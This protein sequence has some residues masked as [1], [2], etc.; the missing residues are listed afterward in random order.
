MYSEARANGKMNHK[1]V[2]I[3]HPQVF[4]QRSYQGD[5]N[6][7]S[8]LQPLDLAPF[9]DIQLSREPVKLTESLT[10]LGEI[11]RRNDFEA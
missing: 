1:P 8:L 10:F 9:F 3:A 7:G 6:I 11:E 5:P 2:L 4:A